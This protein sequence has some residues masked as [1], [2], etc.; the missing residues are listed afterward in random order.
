VLIPEKAQDWQ[1]L[2]DTFHVDPIRT[3]APG[4]TARGITVVE[5]SEPMVAPTGPVQFGTANT[6]LKSYPTSANPPLGSLQGKGLY[7]SKLAYELRGASPA[8]QSEILKSFVGLIASEG[9]YRAWMSGLWDGAF[10]QILTS[11]GTATNVVVTDGVESGGF[12]PAVIEGNG[13]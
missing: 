4:P 12:I 7:V 3:A 6:D 13:R 1:V 2:S 8:A 10:G 9:I 5:H 11:W